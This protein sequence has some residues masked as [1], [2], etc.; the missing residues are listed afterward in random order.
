MEARQFGGVRLHGQTL[1]EPKGTL[2][3]D[4]GSTP[5]ASIARMGENLFSRIDSVVVA[6]PGSVGDGAAF[7][8][9][10]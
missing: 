4:A 6:A 10:G 1:A 7:L 9:G 8:R 2:C 3:H 5:A